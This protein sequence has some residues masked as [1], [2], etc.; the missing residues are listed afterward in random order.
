MVIPVARLICSCRK[1]REKMADKKA[2][3][4]AGLLARLLQRIDV[5][6]AEAIGHEEL[7]ALAR[8]LVHLYAGR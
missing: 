1:M 7:A 3:N 2:S 8:G 6:K 4:P 5:L